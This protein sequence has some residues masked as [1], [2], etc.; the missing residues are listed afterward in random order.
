MGGA[1]LLGG[2]VAVGASFR[3]LGERWDVVVIGAGVAG[4]S[5]A[6]NLSDHGLSVVVVE[7][8]DRIGGQ[9]YTDRGFTSVPVEL[10]AGLIHGRDAYT[11]ELVAE[12]EAETVLVGPSDQTADPLSTPEPPHDGEDAAAYLNRLGIPEGRWP[13]VSIDNEPMHRWSARWMHD[14]GLFDWW[15]TPRENF[16]VVDG[17]DRILSPL[18]LGLDIRLSHA[19]RRVHWSDRGVVLSVDALEG[20]TEIRADRCVITLPI[21]VLKSGDVVF[22]PE[23][24]DDHREAIRALDRT[25]AL[26]L[27]YEFDRPVFPAE[28][29]VLG[30]DED[31]G[32]VFWCLSREDPEVVVA[33]AAGENARRLTALAV[34]DRFAAGLAALAEA[35]D[36]TVPEPR[37]RSTHD[38]ATDEFS[39]G[40][41]LFVP[42]GA[43]DAPAA[44]AAPVRGVLY[45][46]GEPTTGE[47]TV[48]GAYVS[49]Y[50]G[51]DLLLADL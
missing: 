16:R 41:Y 50:D 33:W 35:L 44:L 45:F 32:F 36:E 46:M 9:L 12:A 21:G 43:H 40:A 22:S 15:S 19:V 30:W 24:P 20:P 25:D 6:R 14:S 2:A 8:R 5:A 7:A 29:D 17:Y 34:E 37:A 26:K 27:V 1:V 28:K 11:W 13:P 31:T 49:G 3:T 23:L 51:T 10:G 42:P 48:E 39:A 47:N 4:L 18:A 38:W